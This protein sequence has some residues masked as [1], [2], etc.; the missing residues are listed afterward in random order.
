[1]ALT[2]AKI[3]AAKPGE[4]PYKLA[5]GQ[6]L[7]LNITPPGGK[8]WRGKYYFGGK[9]GLATYGGYPEV[10][11]KE[12]RRKHQETRQQLANGI[13]PAHKKRADK[14]AS[15]LSVENSFERVAEEW[16]AKKKPTWAYNHWTK[17]A[18]MMRQGLFPSIGNR[19]IADIK[20]IE[21][22]AALRKIE[23]RGKYETAK[24][25]KQIASQIFR[26]A[27]A[28][29]RTESDPC[30]DLD[31]ALTPPKKR[32]FPAITEPKQVGPLLRAFDS[33]SGSAVV[34]AALKLGPLTF[35]RPGE[36]RHGRW[37]DIDWQ[38]KEWRFVVTK[39]QTNHIVPL[40]TQA[41]AV[42]EELYPL[43]NRSEYIFPSQRSAKRPMSDNAVLSAMRRMDIGKDEMCGH[44]FRAMARTILD[45]VLQFDIAIIE[46][47]LAH[48][49]R[50]PNGRAYNRTAHLPQRHQ[51]MQTWADYL[52]SLASEEHDH[53]TYQVA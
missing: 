28:T 14:I 29:G 35:V 15:Q 3:R 16:F 9:E 46:H 40:S 13:N 27:V 43:T 24:R 37:E 48:V 22:L 1:M 32:H 49:V 39:T 17:V 11:L 19:A 34:R 50:D 6:G 47:Q 31:G 33:Y 18:R 26:Y 2:D 36:L 21:V 38:E 25:T 23:S 53:E 41:M 5:D 12:A 10:S 8:L 4:K 20:P 7:F 45:E 42:L 51:M 30:R 44:G 52:D